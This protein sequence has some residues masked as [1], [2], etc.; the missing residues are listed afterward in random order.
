MIQNTSRDSKT[1]APLMQNV[2]S[3]L[4]QCGCQVAMWD[5]YEGVYDYVNY[6]AFEEIAPQCDIVVA[7]GGDG[8]ILHAAKHAF[9]HEKLL[10][11][12]NAGRFGYL[13]QLEPDELEKL[14]RLATGEYVVHERMLLEIGIDGETERHYA[15]NDVVISRSGPSR[16]VDLELFENERQIGSYRADGLIFATPTGSTA[17]S[18]AA[19]GPIVDPNL[20]TIIVTPIC[21]SSLF[22]RPMLLSPDVELQVRSRYVNHSDRVTVS[23]DGEQICEMDETKFAHI[24]KSK[25]TVQFIGFESGHFDRLLIKKLKSRG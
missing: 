21:P 14:E 6:G 11:G 3:K 10:L 18:L 23:V 13:A 7:I 1:L 8:T 22:D 12:I 5:R 19:G 17:Y 2:I 9:A 24:Q 16:L 20:D 4:W 25:K 15:L